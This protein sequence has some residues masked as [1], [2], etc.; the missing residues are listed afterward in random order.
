MYDIRCF[1]P[2][3]H[4]FR[5][6]VCGAVL[7][8]YAYFIPYAYGT[9]HTRMVCTIR[10]RY[11]FVYHAYA[12]GMTIRVWYVYHTRITMYYARGPTPCGNAYE[13]YKSH[14]FKFDL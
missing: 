10:V 1:W 11:N 6:L 7:Y 13:I 14:D 9:Y 12:Y 5:T 3:K 4:A 2:K 8:R